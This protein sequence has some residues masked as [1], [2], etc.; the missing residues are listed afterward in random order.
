MAC[1]VRIGPCKTLDLICL[2]L[3][4]GLGLMLVLRVVLGLER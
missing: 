2:T 3:V 1:N 4:L